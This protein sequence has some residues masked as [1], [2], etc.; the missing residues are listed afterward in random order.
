MPEARPQ[1]ASDRDE[2]AAASVR[3]VS[4]AALALQQLLGEHAQA[5]LA[6]PLTLAFSGQPG[7][8]PL[9]PFPHIHH[10]RPQ[11]ETLSAFF[12]F[13]LTLSLPL[14]LPHTLSLSLSQ[15]SLPLPLSLY[16]SLRE[17]TAS[18]KWAEC[19]RESGPSSRL[20][21]RLCGPP[22]ASTA[23]ST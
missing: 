21:V 1:E 17:L 7:R 15:P 6:K 3:V 13:L 2:A 9:S 23:A 18:R 5:P 11:R 19:P 10:A 4:G 16:V 20:R 8:G 22:K 14:S 12:P